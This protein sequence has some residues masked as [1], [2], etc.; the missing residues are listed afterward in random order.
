LPVFFQERAQSFFAFRAYSFHQLEAVE[1][2]LPQIGAISCE[3]FCWNEALRVA[4]FDDGCLEGAQY[5]FIALSLFVQAFDF[6][7]EGSDSQQ[8]LF[9]LI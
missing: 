2:A 1:D 8:I 4:I 7:L 5:G 9:R 3:Q 6:L